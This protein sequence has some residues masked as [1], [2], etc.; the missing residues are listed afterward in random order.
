MATFTW[1][2]TK[3]EL[4]EHIVNQPP[5]GRATFKVAKQIGTVAE[6]VLSAHRDKGHAEIEVKRGSKR[7]DAFVNLKD[8]RGAKAA[9]AIEFGHVN[10]R[11][12]KFVQGLAP[13]RK[14]IASVT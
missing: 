7:V 5:V 13:L 8:D 14:G 4:Y 12:G 2:K 11:S 3:S 9:A 1:L 6:G 10:N